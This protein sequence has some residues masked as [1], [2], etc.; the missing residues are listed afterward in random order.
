MVD[1]RGKT[2]IRH[3]VGLKIWICK[4]SGHEVGAVDIGCGKRHSKHR[5]R[6]MLMGSMGGEAAPL[7]VF[8]GIGSP[9]PKEGWFQRRVKGEEG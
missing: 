6:L 3:K 2:G 7:E 9:V 8:P 1:N 4:R 5:R